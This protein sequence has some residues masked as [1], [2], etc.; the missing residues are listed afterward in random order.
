MTGKE[1]QL[2]RRSEPNRG[3]ARSRRES[4]RMLCGR[5]TRSFVLPIGAVAHS[6]VALPGRQ[7]VRNIEATDITSTVR[8][9]PR[10]PAYAGEN[11]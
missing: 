1:S 10:S 8:G 2:T 7:R 9:L 4:P 5:F 6:R 3:K 11:D